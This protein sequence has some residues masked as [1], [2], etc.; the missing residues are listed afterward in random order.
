MEPGINIE[1]FYNRG[2]RLLVYSINGEEITVPLKSPKKPESTPIGNR[3]TENEVKIKTDKTKEVI[4]EYSTASIIK[5]LSLEPTISV[6]LSYNRG[7]RL[8]VIKKGRSERTIN[9]KSPK[10]PESTPFLKKK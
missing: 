9:L 4:Y 3:P 7:N 2:N 1:I 10:K 5:N 6:T 8:I